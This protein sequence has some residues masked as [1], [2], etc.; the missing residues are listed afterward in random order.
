MPRIQSETMPMRRSS[1]RRTNATTIITVLATLTTLMASSR[2]RPVRIACEDPA[3]A[4]WTLACAALMRP[5]TSAF[6][7]SETSRF[8]LSNSSCC[9]EIV[10][11]EANRSKTLSSP[12]PSSTSRSN[13]EADS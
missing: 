6:S 5:L 13:T 3:V 8:W 10:S 7:S 12:D 4:S 11:S 2:I 1:T 9:M